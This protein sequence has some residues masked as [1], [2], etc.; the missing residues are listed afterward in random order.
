MKA[1]YNISMFILL[2]W[3]VLAVFAPVLPLHPDQIFL[4]KI[5]LS[6]DW[7]QWLGYDD[8]GR[9]ISAR[10]I[11]GARTSL[12]VAIIV[13]AI[14]FFLGTFL[15]LMGAWLGGFWDKCLI[16]IVDLFIAFP[17][18]LLAIALA[19]LLGPGLIN[20]VIALSIVSWVGFA[21]LARVQTL[22]IKNRDHV[23]AAQ[24]LG[25]PNFLIAIKHI[26]PL[27][28]APLIIEATFAFAGVVIAE[29]GLSFLGLGVQPPDASWGS[30]IRDG[31]RYML[32]AP[33]M[34]LAPGF[35]I[36]SLVL[37]IN[38]LGDTLRDKMDIREQPTA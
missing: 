37:C 32:I 4:D 3:L 19:G 25:T 18:I 5:L 22:T 20:A 23:N 1:C 14:S 12:T 36:L 34:V 8:L 10:L 35:A 28:M 29:A 7:Q 30:M 31:T 38:L 26:L 27:I 9:S 24:A 6:P 13:V 21:R 17:G 2:A 16:I 11:M 33:H 15:G